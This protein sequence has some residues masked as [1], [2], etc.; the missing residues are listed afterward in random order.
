MFLIPGPC[1][2]VLTVLASDGADWTFD[3]PVWE[4]VSVS[5]R[6]RTPNWREMEF[7]REIWFLPSETVVQF[8]VPRADHINLHPFCLH[9]WRPVGVDI[10]RPP[11]GTVG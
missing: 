9:M 5:T 7:V 2:A 3:P 10:P 6:S 1:N 8:S 11:A 4:H